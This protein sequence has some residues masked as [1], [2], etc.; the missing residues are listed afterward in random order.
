MTNCGLSVG[1]YFVDASWSSISHMFVVYRSTVSGILVNC[2]RIS[3]MCWVSVK[4]VDLATESN[5]ILDVFHFFQ[6]IVN[7]Y[8]VNYQRSVGEVLVK[9]RWSISEL[10]AMSAG[11]IDY[12]LTTDRLLTDVSTDCQQTVDQY[13]DR[14]YPQ[15]TWSDILK[16][17]GNNSLCSV[18]KVLLHKKML[19]AWV[20]IITKLFLL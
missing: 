4:C 11:S 18:C 7:G 17:C 10:K 14:D 1:W 9:Y 16:G 12:L 13:I 6:L 19:T 20:I 5:G 15:K 3:V 8:S 2:H